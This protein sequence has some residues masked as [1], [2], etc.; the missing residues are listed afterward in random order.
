MEHRLSARNGH[1]DPH[2]RMMQYPTSLC[3]S[4]T[5][6]SGDRPAYSGSAEMRRG[7]RR[8]SRSSASTIKCPLQQTTHW[9]QQTTPQR[10]GC[11]NSARNR[12]ASSRVPFRLEKVRS[13]AGWSASGAFRSTTCQWVSPSPCQVTIAGDTGAVPASCRFACSRT[14]RGVYHTTAKHSTTRFIA[15]IFSARRQFQCS[16]VLGSMRQGRRS[17]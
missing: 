9:S 2:A 12:R 4:R 5:T 8:T 15:S 11:G 10:E 3:S 14:T 7:S 13:T 17:G 6:S 16:Q 1:G